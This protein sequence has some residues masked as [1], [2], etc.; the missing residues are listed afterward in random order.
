VPNWLNFSKYINKIFQLKCKLYAN[1]HKKEYRVY[2]DNLNKIF[3][4]E[5]AYLK[6]LIEK[7]G[8]SR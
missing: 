1:L 8:L 4:L 6:R 5:E 3:V 7:E 2:R